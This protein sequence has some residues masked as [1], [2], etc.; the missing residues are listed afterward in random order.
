MNPQWLTGIAGAIGFLLAGLMSYLHFRHQARRALL[1]VRSGAG[2][3][4]GVNAWY[5][6]TVLSGQGVV[7]TFRH[8]FES[9]LLLAGLTGLV[10]L[11]VHLT[12]SLRGLDGF[13]FLLAG[14]VEVG[15]L[16]V[17][18]RGG[19]NLNYKPWFIS[20]SLA[21][22]VSA[23]CFASAGAAGV[24]FLLVNNMLRTRRATTLVGHVAP[25][26]SLERFGRW[27]LML[28]FPLFSYGILTGICGIAH[29]RPAT[30]WFQDPSVML[31]FVTWF[32][33][34]VMVSF[35]W[36]RPQFRGRRAAAFAT[37]GM[38]LV[39]VVFLFVEFISPLHR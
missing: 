39:T 21:F 12:R 34:A 22:A 18:H 23:A 15:A 19:S 24:A 16:F 9:T 35:M 4:V 29:S 3:A 10:G 31:S 7:E 17:I 1:A 33:Y 25:L 5:F 36:F 6:F 8:G 13:L 30:P 20:H 32:L 37:C 38:G 28:G 27:M 11:I 2:L 26:E 14:L